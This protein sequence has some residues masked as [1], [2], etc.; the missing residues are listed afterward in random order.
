MCLKCPTLQIRS[1][2]K[3]SVKYSEEILSIGRNSGEISL[4]RNNECCIQ[5]SQVS[6]HREDR[7]QKNIHCFSYK[8]A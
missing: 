1:S 6:G 4:Q 5:E 2:V 7:E 3:S 8:C